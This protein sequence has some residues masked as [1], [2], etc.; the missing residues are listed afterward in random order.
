M[1]I[2]PN[3]WRRLEDKAHELRGLTLDTVYWAGGGHVGGSLSALDVL[4]VLY[5]DVMNFSADKLDDPDRDRFVLSKGHIGVGYAPLLADLGCFPKDWLKRFNKTGSPLGIHPDGSKVPGVEIATGSLGHGLSIAAGMANASR[6]SGR[7]FDVYCMMGDGECDE[8]SVWEAAMAASHFKLDR[9]IGIVDR[10]K[11]MIDGMTEDVMN[12]EPFADKWRAF[13][14]EVF[15]IDGSSIPEIYDA[16]YAAR[17]VKGKPAMIIANT[18]KGAGIDSIAGDYKWHYG[19]F[20]EDQVKDGHES[21]E[22][23]H[24]QRVAKIKES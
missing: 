18:V 12:L 6:L 9:L 24:A 11:A 1:S 7:N 20:S 23:Y 14:W 8:G 5:Y 19:S 3:T 13:G 21:L 4:T 15:D 17:E 16:I 2:D 22:R 10:N